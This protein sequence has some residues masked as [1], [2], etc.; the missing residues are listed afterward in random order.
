[1]KL[2][3]NPLEYLNLKAQRPGINKDNGEAEAVVPSMK[4][5]KFWQK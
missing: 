3:K 5:A 1:M 4:L 2:N